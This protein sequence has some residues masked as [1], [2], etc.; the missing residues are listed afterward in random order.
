MVKPTQKH[1]DNAKKILHYPSELELLHKAQELAE[2]EVEQS[3]Y[4]TAEQARALG[5]GNA[6]FMNDFGEWC[7]C[8]PEHLN[9]V[10]K[11]RAIN[12]PKPAE[13]QNLVKLDGELMSREA[14][15]AKYEA[16]KDKCDVYCWSKQTPEFDLTENPKWLVNG[17]FGDEYQLRP[18]AKK[19]ISWSSLPVGVAIGGGI[20][21]GLHKSGSYTYATPERELK[22]IH[23]PYLPTLAPAS[24][25]QLRIKGDEFNTA[26]IALT[27]VETEIY[28][29]DITPLNNYPK[30]RNLG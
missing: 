23:R 27:E 3:E 10:A 13:P 28:M 7:V 26:D 21:L 6:E 8:G 30:E 17:K 25:Q 15:I 14:A 4:I 20:Y 24:E 5:A 19:V 29:R 12:Q 2:N 9:Y 1:I 16:V 22:Y 11:Y 18:K